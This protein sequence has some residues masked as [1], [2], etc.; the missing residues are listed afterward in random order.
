MAATAHPLATEAAVQ[1]LER[2]GNAVDAAVAA[3]FAIGVVEPDGSGLGGGGGMLVYLHDRRETL[4]INYYHQ[5]PA[6]PGAISFRTSTDRNTAKSVLVPGTVAGLCEALDRYGTLPLPVVIEPAIRFARDGFT[7]DATLAGL[8]LDS[9]EQLAERPEL[10]EVFLTDGFPKM[11]GELMV[12]P[13]LAR[14]LQLVSDEGRDGFYRGETAEALVA[15]LTAQGGVMT[16]EDLAAFEPMANEPV[17]GRYRDLEIVSAPPPHSGVTLIEILNMI[18]ALEFDPEVHF[19]QSAEDIHMMAEIFRRAYADRSQYLGDPRF[20]RTPVAGLIAKGYA[21]E[22]FCGINPYRA[23]PRNY[24]D[25][26]YGKPLKFDAARAE[27]TDTRKPAKRPL[28]W[29]DD[30]EDLPGILDRSRRDPFD[31]W[32]DRN[33]Q[34]ADGSNAQSPRRRAR[35]DDD[36]GEFDGG[37]TTHLSVIDA[38]SNMVALTQTLGNFFGSKVMI[39]G[40]LLNNGRVN[41]S[42]KSK[43]NL[44]EPNK[45]PRSSLTPTLVFRDGTPFM[46]LGSPGAG[47]IIATVAQVIVNVAD[48]DMDVRA[49]ND[50]PRVFCQKFD[51][52]LSLESRVAEGVAESLTRKGHNVR[53]LGDYD[54]FFGGVQ[55]TAIDPA[56]GEMVGSADPRRGGSAESLPPFPTTEAPD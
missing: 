10:A 34:G 40:I 36:D 11:Q 37:H 39:N 41:Y 16:L 43:S 51:D 9:M 23:E 27:P 1:M 49:A 28:T 29:D 45:R 22:I 48:Y 53:V 7:V 25:T 21:A 20:V 32:G 56:S 14:V 31:R 2:G 24:R 46:S 17:R 44:I 38:D 50:A 4:Y 52:H 19:S 35:D 13:K 18:E 54:L 8:I 3:A 47:R 12:Q 5:A 42:D 30:N 26:P 15:G 33:R 6:A 55:M